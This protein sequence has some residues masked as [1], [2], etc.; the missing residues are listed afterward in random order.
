MDDATL[1]ALLRSHLYAVLARGFVYPPRALADWRAEADD[2]GEFAAAVEK[3][4]GGN[5]L[6]SDLRALERARESVASPDDLERLRDEWIE[7]FGNLRTQ[8]FPPYETEYTGG[9]DFRQN[10]DLADL[11]GFYRAFGLNLREA[12]ERRERPDHLAVELEFLHFLCWKEAAARAGR[13][14]EHVEVCLDAE[15]KFLRDHLGRWADVFGRGV[16]K[17]AQSSFYRALAGLLRALVAHEAVSLGV[18]PDPVAVPPS[19]RR[20]E[21]EPMTCGAEAESPLVQIQGGK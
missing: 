21:P 1:T 14:E 11:T 9:G 8:Q 15:R 10:Q 18:T 13:N 4:P 7:F 2:R 20:R 12:E 16:E 17:T 5:A 3:L 6:A 19:R